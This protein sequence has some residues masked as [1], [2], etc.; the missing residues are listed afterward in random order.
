MLVLNIFS[1]F[2]LTICLVGLKK[3]PAILDLVWDGWA[4]CDLFF[5]GFGHLC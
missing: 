3:K 2:V 1:T 5:G 4:L